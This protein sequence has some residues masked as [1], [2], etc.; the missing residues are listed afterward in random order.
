MAITEAFAG[1]AVAGYEKALAW[2][3]RLLGRP[4]D[5]IP[6]ENEAVWQLTETG[7]IYLVGDSHRAGNA[8]LTLIVDDLEHRVADIAERGLAM[9]EIE[10]LPGVGRKAVITDPEGNMI[11]FAELS[12]AITAS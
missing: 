7:L 8:L 9:G 12:T 11:T 2:Y 10:A 6:N 5:M 4:P 3:E 1:I